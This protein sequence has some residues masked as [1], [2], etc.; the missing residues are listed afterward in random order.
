MNEMWDR[1][2]KAARKEF[3]LLSLNGRSEGLATVWQVY[4]PRDRA[5]EPTFSSPSKNECLEFMWRKAMLAG[6]AA[7][8]EPTQAMCE[9]GYAEACRHDCGH[10]VPHAEIAP[11]TWRAMIDE[12]LK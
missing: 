11:E 8:R 2:A 7:M 5:G 12:A 9:A 4:R 3:D 6:I 10:T 1:A